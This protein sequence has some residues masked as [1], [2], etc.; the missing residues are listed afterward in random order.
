MSRMNI[1]DLT[2]LVARL[3]AKVYMVNPTPAVMIFHLA[4]E[5]IHRF[6]D[7]RHNGQ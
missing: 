5:W 6:T 1:K 2:H 4:Q 3:E 7:A